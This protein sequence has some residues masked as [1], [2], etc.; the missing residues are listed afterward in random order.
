MM[1]IGR[2]YEWTAKTAYERQSPPLSILPSFNFWWPS[3]SIGKEVTGS[4]GKDQKASED[5]TWGLVR[6]YWDGGVDGG[7]VWILLTVL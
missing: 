3:V 7:M 5:G 4:R 2:N 1:W 6:G